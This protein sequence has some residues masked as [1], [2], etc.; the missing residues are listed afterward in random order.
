MIRF[1][2]NCSQD[3]AFEGWFK[4]GDAFEQQ[5]DEGQV[6]CPTC[7][8]RAIRKAMMAPAI[9]RSTAGRRAEAPA[10]PVEPAAEQQARAAMLLAMMR[11]VR[12]HV[13]QNFENVGDRFPEEVRRVHYG[14]AEAR[15]LFGQATLDEAKELLEEGIPVRPL[16]EL[17]KLDG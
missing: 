13:E 6:A 8:D 14:E 7:G 12:E 1:A 5:A 4:S 16:P 3:H 2:L 11:K 17:P 15:D 9:V 10:A